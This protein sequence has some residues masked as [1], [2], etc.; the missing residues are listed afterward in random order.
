[1]V[2]QQHSQLFKASYSWLVLMDIKKL[3]DIGVDVNYANDSGFTPL[4][5]SAKRGALEDVKDLVECGASINSKDNQ[6]FCALYYA[7]LYN[8][9]DVVEYLVNNGALVND[10]IYMTARH[11]NYKD[12]SAYF[13][14]L[15]S[16]RGK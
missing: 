2:K 3:C 15:D 6:D 10:A 8:H 4:M 1:M 14:S 13:D 12:I 5:A 11:K 9:F 7:T 16:H